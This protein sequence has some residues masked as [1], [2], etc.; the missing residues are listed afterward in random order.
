[1]DVFTT[2]V[3][4][5]ITGLLANRFVGGSGYGPSRDIAIGGVGALLGNWIVGALGAPASFRGAGRLGFAEF[6]GAA[7]LLVILRLLRNAQRTHELWT[8]TPS[9]STPWR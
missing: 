3:I 6:I 8:R 2:L 7:G 9:N 4:G 1:M 5:L